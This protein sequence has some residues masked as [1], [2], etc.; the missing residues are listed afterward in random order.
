MCLHV[1]YTLVQRDQHVGEVFTPYESACARGVEAAGDPFEGLVVAEVVGDIF[2][3]GV[4]SPLL[5]DNG[6]GLGLEGL[7]LGVDRFEG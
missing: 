7:C 3:D 1:V 6:G 2:G 5:L 4:V